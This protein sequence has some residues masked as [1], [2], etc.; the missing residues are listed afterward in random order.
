MTRRRRVN[1]DALFKNPSKKSFKGHGTTGKRLQAA[2]V[3]AGRD[4]GLGIFGGI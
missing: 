2:M 3:K 4:S 1:A